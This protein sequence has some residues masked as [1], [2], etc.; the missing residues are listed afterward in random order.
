MLSGVLPVLQLPYHDDETIDWAVLK[1]E[2]DHVFDHGAHGIVAAMV[3]EVL[4][5]TDAER[6]E[7]AARL[8]E[9]AAG[10]GPVVMSVGGE[11]SFHAVRHAQA[12]EKAGVHALMAIPPSCTR[13]SA[14]EVI[15]YYE[16][17]LAATTLPLVVQ[18]ASGY[19]GV[20][21]PIE[22]QAD[23]FHRHPNRVMFKPESPPLGQNLSRLR[24]AVG[25]KAA[26]FEGSGGIG[27]TDAYRRGIAGTMPGAEMIGAIRALWDALEAGDFARATPLQGLIASLVTLQQGLDGYLAVEK[28]LHWKQGLFP[29]RLVRGPLGF[30]LDSETEAEVLRLFEALQALLHR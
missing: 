25:R 30:H 29:N 19:V 18:D 10:R 8:V 27:L 13:A 15:G 9:F 11:S 5:L 4:R 16:R 12:A 17:L 20:P 22:A 24:D 28:L 14:A 23:L 21:L 7:L 3:T 1:R 26:I 2:V 6:D